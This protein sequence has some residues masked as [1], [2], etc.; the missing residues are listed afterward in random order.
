MGIN[1]QCFGC[2]FLH[3]LLHGYTSVMRI[4]A[5]S[6]GPVRRPQCCSHS[7]NTISAWLRSAVPV[8]RSRLRPRSVHVM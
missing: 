4:A 5:E 3:L 2:H 1:N 7:A 8:V 6:L